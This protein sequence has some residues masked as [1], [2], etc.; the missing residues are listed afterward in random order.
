VVIISKWKLTQFFKI[1]VLLSNHAI[2]TTKCQVV[3]SRA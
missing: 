2:K 3:W 1:P